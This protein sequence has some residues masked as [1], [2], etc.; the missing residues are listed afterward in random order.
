ME[1]QMKS[2]RRVVVIAW[3]EQTAAGRSDLHQQ[4][5]EADEARKPDPR[6][7]MASALQPIK[8]GRSPLSSTTEQELNV[9]DNILRNVALDILTM[10]YKGRAG[11][12]RL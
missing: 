5:T 11:H 4:A 7:R 12:R 3:S 9:M 10:Q 8:R 1:E 6:I 2:G